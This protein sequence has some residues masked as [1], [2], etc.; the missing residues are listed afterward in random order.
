MTVPQLFIAVLWTE[1]E[2]FGEV[3]ERPTPR[4]SSDSLRPWLDWREWTADVE[5]SGVRV[6]R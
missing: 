3:R 5:C 4:P 1:D 2:T 6:V